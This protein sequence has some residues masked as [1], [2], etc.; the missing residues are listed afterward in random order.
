MHLP[1]RLGLSLA[2]ASIFLSACAA[3]AA[4]S[5]TG[6]SPDRSS[7]GSVAGAES[8]QSQSLRVEMGDWFYEPAS[9]TVRTGTVN[10]TLVNNSEER[11]HTFVIRNQA[12][13]GNLA[14]SEPIEAG[15]TGT[16][17]FNISAPG[18]YEVFCRL[19]GHADRGQKGTLTVQA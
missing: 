18:T 1:R 7:S 2:G 19:R 5:A 17:A 11:Q 8:A 9:W 13:E 10:V 3:P 6:A 16:L 4:P 12:G 14:E 15:A